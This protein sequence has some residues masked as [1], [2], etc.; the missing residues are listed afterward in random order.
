ML[1]PHVH[2]AILLRKQ[3]NVA[4]K[5]VVDRAKQCLFYEFLNLE[6]L[7]LKEIWRLLHV[8]LN[9]YI[10]Q[11]LEVLILPNPRRGLVFKHLPFQLLYSKKCTEDTLLPS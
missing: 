1:C 7:I 8:Y 10:K 9:P 6:Q 2:V 11:R 4:V 3:K 5:T